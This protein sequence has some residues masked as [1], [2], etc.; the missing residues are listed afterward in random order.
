MVC[1]LVVEVFVFC[2]FNIYLFWLHRVLV[3][4][5]GI[6]IEACG[7]LVVACMRDLFPRLGIEPGP[8]ALGMQSLTHWATR[9]VPLVVEF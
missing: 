7:L 8:P 1:S 6:F 5:H 9:E 4:A 3:V 2:F